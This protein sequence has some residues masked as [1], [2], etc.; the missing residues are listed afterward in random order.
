MMFRRQDRHRSRAT[1]RRADPFGF[2]VSRV[3]RVIGNGRLSSGIIELPRRGE[4]DAAEPLPRLSSVAASDASVLVVT[5]PLARKRLAMV[6]DALREL[7]EPRDVVTVELVEGGPH[8]SYATLDALPN[9]IRVRARIRLGPGEDLAF[10]VARALE[11]TPPA[12]PEATRESDPFLLGGAARLVPALGEE[13]EDERQA[14]QEGTEEH[15]EHEERADHEDARPALERS[16]AP[17]TKAE[18]EP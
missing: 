7:R 16:A 8:R 4:R 17:E 2:A 6:H 13:A 5:L 9:E 14:E 15:E 11:P 12:V 3:A 1:G 18:E 10:R